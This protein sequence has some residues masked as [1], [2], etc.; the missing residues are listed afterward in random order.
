MTN[1]N[2]FSSEFWSDLSVENFEKGVGVL[3]N[4][5]VVG[6][7]LAAT[8]GVLAAPITLPLQALQGEQVGQQVA[9]SNNNLAASINNAVAAQK[10]AAQKA[11]TQT[12]ARSSTTSATSTD[13]S[14][15]SGSGGGQPDLSGSGSGG[16]I[17][18]HAHGAEQPLPQTTGQGS[19]VGGFLQS[20]WSDLT[21]PTNAD[22]TPKTTD[23]RVKAGAK[24]AAV[25]VGVFMATALAM[26]A[27][28]HRSMKRV[29]NA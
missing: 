12:V 21:D 2:P 28:Q 11:M 15:S 14:S 18:M 20:N 17:S 19:G 24:L 10:A 9:A 7:A 27:W 22:G 5:P 16:D 8:A 26:Q 3:A 13:T 25:G 29:A 6:P 23:Q 4:V 1:W